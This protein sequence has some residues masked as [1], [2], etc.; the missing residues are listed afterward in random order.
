ME[1]QA[2][3]SLYFRRDIARVEAEHPELILRRGENILLAQQAG[4]AKLAYSFESDRAFTELF[5]DMLDALL[6]RIRR[7]LRAE[8]VRFRLSHSPSRPL[9]EPVVKRLL[10]QPKRE[11]LQFDIARGAAPKHT[12]V[13]GIRF[14]AATPA[15]I[16]AI[17]KIDV[18]AFPNQPMPHEAI[19]SEL[20]ESDRSVIVAVSKAGVVG[21]CSYA[22]P[23]P[24]FGYIHYLAVAASGRQRGIGG[25]LTSRALKALF[26]AGADDVALT[27]EQNNGPA[28]RL[29]RGLGFRQTKAGR[30]YERPADPRVIE[31]L[32]KQAQTTMIKFG[33]WR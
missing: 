32:A 10:F 28:I 2:L 24:R 22:L 21:Y 11:W 20:F 19:R 27:T 12:A 33:D 30:D 17:G 8:S 9:V 31:R 16:D 1:A 13:T 15:D 4:A 3:H 6:P 7:A 25:A 18:E 26:A 29:Y 14:R 23:D 5:P